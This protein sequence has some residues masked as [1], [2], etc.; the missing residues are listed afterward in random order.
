MHGEGNLD[1]AINLLDHTEK[2]DF[3]DFVNKR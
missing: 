3:T 1:K 2:K